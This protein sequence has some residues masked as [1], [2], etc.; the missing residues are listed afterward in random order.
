MAG[1]VY[2]HSRSSLEPSHG[3]SM[4]GTEVAAA[5][6]VQEREATVR[7][8]GESGGGAHSRLGRRQRAQQVRQAAAYTPL[9]EPP[10]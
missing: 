4:S 8:A 6:V 10:C 2:A 3:G 7:A 5:P 9:L 1:R